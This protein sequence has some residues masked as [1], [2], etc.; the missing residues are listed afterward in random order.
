VESSYVVQRL[1]SPAVNAGKILFV[2]C[3][4]WS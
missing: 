3:A 1:N 2:F 4:S